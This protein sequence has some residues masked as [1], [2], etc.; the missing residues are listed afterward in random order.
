MDFLKTRKKELIISF[1]LLS[2]YTILYGIVIFNDYKKN[3]N[4]TNVLTK[5]SI[6][7]LYLID[8]VLLI[9]YIIQIVFI[10]V[11]LIYWKEYKVS[12][13][14]IFCSCVVYLFIPLT[15]LYIPYG[16]I[17]HY[18][19]EIID[20]YYY[21]FL[22]ENLYSL[23]NY[24]LH[25]LGINNINFIRNITINDY[26][27]EK[28]EKYYIIEKILVFLSSVITPNIIIFPALINSCNLIHNN[29]GYFT[30]THIIKKIIAFGFIPI[31]AII[32]GILYIITE[33][34]KFIITE[35][36][37]IT[38]ILMAQ[39]NIKSK[40][41]KIIIKL[42]IVAIGVMAVL[43]IVDYELNFISIITKGIIRY[44]YSIILYKDIII[45]IIQYIY[46]NHKYN[47]NINLIQELDQDNNIEMNTNIEIDINKKEYISV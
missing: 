35:I 29:F 7:N 37:L 38:Y 30:V 5:D 41:F 43:L 10:L 24:T 39:N 6:Y 3:I 9:T 2:L 42:N 11:A 21:Y 22:N 31:S 1:V 33:N 40:L 26:T 28:F 14:M 44:F 13:I 8:I 19:N 34:S 46:K 23:T 18:D 47:D 16:D 27:I 12:K 45:Y 32:S 4:S 20:Y 17:I 15:L 25:D 36:L